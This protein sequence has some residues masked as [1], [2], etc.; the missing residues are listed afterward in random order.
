MRHHR[1]VF[2][3][4]LNQAEMSVPRI[5]HEWVPIRTAPIKA[6]IRK[7]VF[8]WGSLSVSEHVLERPEVP[9][10]MVK[11]AIQNQVHAPRVQ[12]LA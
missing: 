5:I 10:D 1:W 2:Q 12:L 4:E 3:V 7:P 6:Q 9:A 11:H 8:V